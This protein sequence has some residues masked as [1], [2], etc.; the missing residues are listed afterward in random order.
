[1]RYPV[2]CSALAIVGLLTSALPAAQ[3]RASEEEE[4]LPSWAGEEEE[5]E[6]EDENSRKYYAFGLRAGYWMTDMNTEATVSQGAAL[7]SPIDF[8]TDLSLDDNEVIPHLEGYITTRYFSLFADWWSTKRD[9]TKTLTSTISFRGVSF[10]A[11]T[12]VEAELLMETFGARIELKPV[13]F[14]YFEFAILLGARYYDIEG[15]IS[16][17]NPLIPSAASEQ[18]EGPVPLGGGAIRI[19]P[20]PFGVH[21]PVEIF[22]QFLGFYIKSGEDEVRYVE[23]EAGIGFNSLW[24]HVGV[25]VSYR[26]F[27]AEIQTEENDRWELEL[28]G[29][30]AYI[31]VQL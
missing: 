26:Y 28:S 4:L 23:A 30:A 5:E 10:T 6:E 25:L 2:L 15:T 16:S 19:Y 31:R 8:N 11:S 12:P 24:S 17:T 27:Y 7:G 1:M 21:G 9:G 14:D 18:I 3:V 29:P 13:S 20:G 22:G